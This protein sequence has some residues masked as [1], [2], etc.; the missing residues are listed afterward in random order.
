MG[1]AE[2]ISFSVDL[3]LD[4]PESDYPRSFVK[5]NERAESNRVEF[6][7]WVSLPPI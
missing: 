4:I 2:D 1:V 7:V 5:Y 6:F 3:R